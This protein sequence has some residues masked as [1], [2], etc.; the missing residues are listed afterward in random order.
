MCLDANSSTNP[1]LENEAAVMRTAI[2]RA[3]LTTGD[4]EYVNTHGSSSPLGDETEVGAIQSLFGQDHKPYLNSTKSLTGHCLWSAGIIEAIAVLAQLNNGFLHPDPNLDQPIS[5]D[6][7]WVG[8]TAR[9]TSITTAV[10]N[11]FGFGGINTSVVLE[12]GN[13]GRQ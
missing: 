8:R 6:C 12:S 1:N 2:E 5:S 13:R 11:S 9:Q 7:A 3:G 4:I 10:S